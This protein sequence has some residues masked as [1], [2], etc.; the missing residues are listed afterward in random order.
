MNTRVFLNYWTGSVLAAPKSMP[1]IRCALCMTITLGPLVAYLHHI[2]IQIASN[3]CL[4]Q[5]SKN[6]GCS[7]F[8]YSKCTHIQSKFK[9]MHPFYI[10]STIARHGPLLYWWSGSG[11]S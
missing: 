10:L 1:M 6:V 5:W 4:L 9:K 3:F 2:H 8:E 11:K 7:S